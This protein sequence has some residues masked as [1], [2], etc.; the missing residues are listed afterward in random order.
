[1]RPSGG[2]GVQTHV[3]SVREFAQGAGLSA[4]LVTPYSAPLWQVYPAFALRRLIDPLSSSAGVWWYR[5]GHAAFLT[6]ALRQRLADGAPCTVYAQ[7][8]VSAASALQARRS[9]AQRVCM[10]VHFN[11]SQAEEW[12]EKGA[13]AAGGRHFR[14]IRSFEARI[15]PRLDGIVHVSRF[16]RQLVEARVPRLQHV[17][18]ICLPNFLSDD[19]PPQ[20]AALDASAAPTGAD[21]ITIGS[22]E[23]RKNHAFLLQVLAAADRA[24]K[25]YTLDI[26]GDGPQRRPLESLAR[27]LGLAGRVRFLGNRPEAARL[28][29]GHRAY[30]HAATMEN[31]PLALVE[32]M[33]AGV[34]IVAA[35]VG[36]IAEMFSDG[37][38][39]RHWNLAEPVQ[40]AAIL[41]EVLEREPV[42]RAM[43][44]AARARFESSFSSR[45]V[46]PRLAEFLY[47]S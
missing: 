16:M 40:G 7:C 24:G 11:V 37:V 28:I 22:L 1:M 43:A 46:G 9:S 10:A 35:P 21:L 13:I 23:T 26:I 41:A 31:M 25:A 19:E 36:G 32:S 15:L 34:P 12:A 5:Q 18:A 33:R 47:G 14:A 4:S 17:R 27:G 38:E 8:P 29:G 44:A 45:A 42:R 2:T 30:V 6:R 3:R 39:G 20:Q